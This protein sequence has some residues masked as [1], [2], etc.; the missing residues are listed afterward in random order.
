MAPPSTHSYYALIFI[1]VTGA[2]LL[3]IKPLLVFFAWGPRWKNMKRRKRQQLNS[4]TILLQK[5]A[6]SPVATTSMSANTAVD[7]NLLQPVTARRVV[8]IRAK[9]NTLLTLNPEAC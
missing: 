9:D 8:Q 2:M 3:A 5:D 6:P 7:L 1:N 4:A